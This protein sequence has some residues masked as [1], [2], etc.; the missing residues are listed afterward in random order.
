MYLDILLNRVDRLLMAAQNDP[1]G[2]FVDADGLYHVYYQ[3]PFLPQAYLAM[4]SVL[5]FYR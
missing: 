1:N 3:C 5:T 4:K 2:L